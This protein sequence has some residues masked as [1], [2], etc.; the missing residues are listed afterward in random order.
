LPYVLSA[1]DLRNPVLI[2][3][4][5]GASIAII[6][7]GSFPGTQ[8][9][10]LILEA[11]H[12]FVE[13]E[14]IDSIQQTLREYE[15]GDVRSKLAKYQ[16]HVDHTF[17]SWVRVWLDP[18]FRNWNIEEFL[19]RIQIPSLVIQGEKD[20]FGTIAQVESIRQ[21]SGGPVTTKVLP[22]CGHRP[23]RR[24]PEESIQ[25]IMDFLCP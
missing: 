13:K 18:A 19:P 3:H 1:F 16:D 5:D 25:A 17:N 12:V 6:H 9:R 21:K 22:D 8:I 14:T 11:P 10:A 4:S 23:H 20:E 15:S 2:G 24:Y 7:C